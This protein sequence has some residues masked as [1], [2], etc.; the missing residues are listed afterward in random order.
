M[1]KFWE[2]S[3]FLTNSR[4]RVRAPSNSLFSRNSLVWTCLR[5]ML[6]RRRR[7]AP[8]TRNFAVS[9]CRFRGGR[10]YLPYRPYV[11]YFSKSRMGGRAVIP[12]TEVCHEPRRK[13]AFSHYRKR[14][15]VVGGLFLKSMFSNP[16]PNATIMDTEQPPCG[17][18]K[19]NTEHGRTL[20][21]RYR[22]QSERPKPTPNTNQR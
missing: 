15:C 20:S 2:F 18:S 1:L 9:K 21:T 5:K 7:G 14:P 4:F 11:I 17:T 19:T 10:N 3:N 16:T 13:G 12:R 22:R 6:R 8:K